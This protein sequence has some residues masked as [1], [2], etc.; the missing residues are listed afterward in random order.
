Y[1]VQVYIGYPASATP[2]ADP[3]QGLELASA[4]YD[5]G[6]DIIWQVAGGTGTGVF[7]A[8]ADAGLYSIGVDVDQY[9]SMS[10]QPELANTIV[11]SMLKNCGDMFV[12]AA[13]LLIEGNYPGGE[14]RRLGIADGAVGIAENDRYMELVP[15]EIRTEISA[16]VQKVV[17]GEVEIYSVL[18]DEASWEAI[19]AEATAAR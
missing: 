16:A 5:D 12:A 17:D 6:V 1:D 4:M 11:T 2:F 10:E 18:D 7:Q 14:L 3:A 13:D 9:I 15:E 19:K 8:A